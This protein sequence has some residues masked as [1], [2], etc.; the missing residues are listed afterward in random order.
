MATNEE[1]VAAVQAALDAMSSADRQNSVKRFV[2]QWDAMVPFLPQAEPL[3]GESQ[4]TTF[5]VSFKPTDEMRPE[6]ER[7]SNDIKTLI[8]Q[9]ASAQSQNEPPAPIASPEPS[10]E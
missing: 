2:A 6:V 10:P 8:K 7:I 1:K 5:L 4:E 3:P 9:V